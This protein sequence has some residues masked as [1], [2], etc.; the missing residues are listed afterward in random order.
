MFFKKKEPGKYKLKITCR[1]PKGS[2]K[3]SLRNYPL[4]FSF[5]R[6]LEKGDINGESC[7][8]ILDFKDIKER[9]KFMVKKIPFAETEMKAALALT[10]ATF[11][12][13]PFK[14]MRKIAKQLQKFLDDVTIKE[15][16]IN[17]E[18]IENE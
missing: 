9:D 13:A 11:Q 10:I 8:F 5:K 6:P 17:A 1:N 16:L 7:Y 3:A 14:N 2:T 18:V 4:K 15:D 12:K